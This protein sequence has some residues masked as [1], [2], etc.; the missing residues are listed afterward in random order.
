MKESVKALHKKQLKK[1]LVVLEETDS[2][3]DV[4]IVSRITRREKPVK[5]K[6]REDIWL[7]GFQAGY[8]KAWDSMMPTMLQGIEQVKQKLIEK[9]INETI[10]NL[11]PALKRARGN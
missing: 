4:E 5:P 6:A 1:Q 7:E 2:D 10:D 3:D 9:T 8:S 11:Q